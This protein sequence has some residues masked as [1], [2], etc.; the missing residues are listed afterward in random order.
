[1][2]HDNSLP[3]PYSLGFRVQGT[4]G[5]WMDVNKSIYIQGVSKDETWEDAK[6]YLDKYDH[7]LWK[8]YAADAKGAGH[9]GMD[10]FVVNAF[11]ESIK[12]K[13]ETP[14]D[15][16]DFA[17]WSVVT[18]LSEKSIALG[19]QSVDFP[20]FSNGKWMAKQNKFGKS[21]MW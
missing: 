16:Y 9:G 10:W 20:D 11:I 2:T 14:L 1:M 6:P 4:N 13:Q 17:A 15:V 19:S 5:L 12:N 21:D 3:R 7:P 18:P 8:R